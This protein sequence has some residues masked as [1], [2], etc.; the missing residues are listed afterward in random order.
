MMIH[1]ARPALILAAMF[2]LAACGNGAPEQADASRS[3]PE[4]SA[5]RIKADIAWLADDA[6][7]GRETGSAGY[8]AAADY[9]ATRF[10][11]LGLEPGGV[12]GGYLQPVPLRASRVIPA[13]AAFIIHGVDGEHALAMGEE[14]VAFTNHRETESRVRAPAVFAG[15][16][17]VAPERSHDD[18]AGLDVD[19]KIVVLFGGAPASFPSEIRA[20]YGSGRTKAEVAAAHGAVGMVSI[21]TETNEQRRPFERL[22]GFLDGESM[23]WLAADGTAHVTAPEIRVSAALDSTPTHELFAGAARSYE[24]VRAAEAAGEA[25]PGFPLA[26]ELTLAQASAHRNL[27]SPNVAAVLPGSDP[28]LAD[29]FVTITAHLDHVGTGQPVDGDEIYNGA[30]D[31]AAGVSVMLAAADA[32]AN[33]GTAPRRSILFIA[34]TGEEKGLIGAD[35]FARN[36]TVPKSAIVA[37]VNLDMPLILY[38]FSD[39]VAFGADHSSLGPTATAAVARLGVGLSPDPMPEEGIFTRSDHY[40]FVEQGIPAIFLITG[41]NAETGEGEGGRVFR[42]FL[43]NHYHK[44]SDDIS[45]PIDYEAGAKFALLNYLIVDEIANADARPRWNADSFFG[46]LFAPGAP[47]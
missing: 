37:N 31:N 4:I 10:R 28:G 38:P 34:L 1:R 11:E 30:L 5:D 43:A 19:G 16:G 8:E 13:G 14:F 32:F 9:V 26:V 3:L 24:E 46:T 20:H 33:A 25:T 12:D 21:Y 40:R 47:S 29:E 41:F 39:V 44:P 17:V 18:Y 6:R 36:P 15:Y 2:A 45:L 22:K 27:V 23:T 42:D 35:Y 7:L